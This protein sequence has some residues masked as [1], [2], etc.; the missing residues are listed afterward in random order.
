MKTAQEF[1]SGQ[2]MDINGQPWVVLKAEFNKS[3]RNASVMKMKLKNLLTG[4]SQES[5]FKA[6]DK[7]DAIILER[8]QVTYSYFA[9]PLYVFMDEEYNP[10][11]VEKENLGDAVHFITDGMTE[12]CEATFYDGKAISIEMPVTIVRTVA[13]TEPSARGDTSGKVMKLAKLE[14]GFELQVADFIKIG[15]AIEID[16]RTGEF[17]CRAK[18]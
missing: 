13:Y 1:R 6:D 9:D 10:V 16:S 8:R 17:K 18:A 5:V 14:N 15:E 12:Q 11:E 7:F 3:G 4:S 2:V